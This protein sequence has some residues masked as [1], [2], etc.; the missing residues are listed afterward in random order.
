MAQLRGS[1]NLL[2]LNAYG[3]N[4]GMNPIFGTLIGGGTAAV[5][6][7]A[8]RHTG[9][10][11]NPELFG[12]LGGL[13]ASGLMFS[14]KSTRHAALGSAVGAFFAAGVAWLE[15]TL[16]GAQTVAVPGVGIPTIRGLG[17][18]AARQLNGV[19]IPNISNVSSPVGVAGNQLAQPGHSSPPVS[20]LGTQSPQAAQ[21]RGMGGPT[22]HGLSAAYG[23]TLM[24]MGR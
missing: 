9:T 15:K 7:I 11:N 6:T 24:G 19:G 22:T 16:F 23:A 10:T 13:A 20:L 14:M 2:G 5:T 18:P 8:L 21:L 3:Q 1:V 4:P 12:L 17:I